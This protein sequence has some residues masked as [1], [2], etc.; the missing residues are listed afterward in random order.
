[1]LACIRLKFQ[2]VSGIRNIQ[3]D[4]Y[5][6]IVIYLL[7]VFCHLNSGTPSIHAKRYWLGNSQEIIYAITQIRIQSSI[8]VKKLAFSCKSKLL[9][10]SSD[11][12][13]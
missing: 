5:L 2:I 7:F 12:I 4:W 10:S 3:I 9:H 1:M 11:L 13:L 8:G 6:G